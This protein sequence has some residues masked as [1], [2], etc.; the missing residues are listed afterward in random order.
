MNRFTP[1]A[2]FAAALLFA[3][4]ASACD[5]HVGACE[6]EAWR[7]YSALPGFLTIEGSAT[8]DSGMASIRLYDV[9]GG[10]ERFIGTASGF[11]K[12][13]ALLALSHKIDAPGKLGIR[14]SIE[15]M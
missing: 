5:D 4:H 3:A 2:A 13:H 12:G 8:C 14:V 10:E 15:P 7:A 9:A 1:V 6:L 11:I